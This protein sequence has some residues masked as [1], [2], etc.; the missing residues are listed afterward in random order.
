M[1]LEKEIKDMKE[2]LKLE[3]TLEEKTHLN[4]RIPD[5]ARLCA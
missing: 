5:S 3:V 4:M 2:L 1:E